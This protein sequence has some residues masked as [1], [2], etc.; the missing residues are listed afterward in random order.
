MK[1]ETIV[2]AG[3]NLVRALMMLKINVHSK[4]T[5]PRAVPINANRVA[6]LSVIAGL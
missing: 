3:V 1:E 6:F 4:R 2:T 5:V